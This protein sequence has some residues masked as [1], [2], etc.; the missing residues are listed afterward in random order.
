MGKLPHVKRGE[1][2]VPLA[3]RATTTLFTRS[4]VD[5]SAELAIFS[6]HLRFEKA[7]FVGD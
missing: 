3:K 7:G 1:I 5:P 2:V 6:P 4:T